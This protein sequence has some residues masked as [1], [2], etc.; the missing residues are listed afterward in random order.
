MTDIHHATPSQLAEHRAHAD[1][2]RRLGT[3]I[4]ALPPAQPIPTPKAVIMTLEPPPE[5]HF[6]FSIL[7]ISEHAEREIT[8]AD[9]KRA[10]ASHFAISV[11][12]II[13]ARRTAN[14]IM[15]RQIGIYLAKEL[16]LLSLPDIGR[17][18][19]NRDHT[20]ILHS[21]RKIAA[22]LNDSAVAEAIKQVRSVLLSAS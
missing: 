22:L 9:I 11:R 16:T 13:S 18:F 8:C 21:I 7:E 2:Q 4:V 1:R 12:E 14:I 3:V 19:G 5:P 10:V 6:W 15:P 20:T 17:H